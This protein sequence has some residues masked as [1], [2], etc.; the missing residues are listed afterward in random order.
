MKIDIPIDSGFYEFSTLPLATQRCINWYVNTN[1]EQT[2]TTSNLF[3]IPGLFELIKPSD[4]YNLRGCHVMAGIPYFVIGPFL[5]SL[6][7][8]TDTFGVETFSVTIKGAVTGT[9]RV[10]MADNGTQLCIVVPGSSSYILTSDG[11]FNL[12][13]DSNFDGPAS[14]VVFIDGYFVFTTSDG[15]KF[16]NSPLLDGRGLPTGTAYN[17]LD[18][19]TA[20]ADPDQIRGAINYKNDL[21]ILGSETTEV[22]QNTGRD[23]APFAP[24]RGFILNKGLAAPFSLIA[25][26][27]TFVFVGTGVGESPAVWAFTG[28]STAKLSTTPIDHIL[29]DL[30]DTEV[31][32][33]FAWSY[34]EAGSFF[35]GFQLPETC[36][37]YDFV[38]G[39]WHERLSHTDEDGVIPYRVGGSCQA[40]GRILVGDTIDGRIGEIARNLYTEYGENIRRSLITRPFDNMGNSMFVPAIEVVMESGSGNASSEDPMI[41]LSWSDDGGRTYNNE[42][43]RPIGKVGE[44]RNRTIWRRLGRTPRSRVLKFELSESIRPTFIKAEADIV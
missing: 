21:Y 13:V 7:R 2:V 20:E 1:T 29:S 16:F 15:K 22:F 30:T 3:G 32:N 38:S 11:D 24:I 9:S 40:Y 12:I 33:I 34:S 25:T 19:S 36:F 18:F 41:R 17:A 8:V 27:N 39:K 26:P 37:V 28:N 44:Y 10:S 42:L 5:Y 23:P 14:S 6:D 31:S 43:Q 35:V 4:I